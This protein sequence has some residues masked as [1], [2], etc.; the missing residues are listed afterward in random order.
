[1]EHTIICLEEQQDEF[2][3]KFQTHQ[4]EGRQLRKFWLWHVLL[5]SY[6]KCDLILDSATQLS[7]TRP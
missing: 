7:Q 6:G 3:F 4:M 5:V 1:M 2:D